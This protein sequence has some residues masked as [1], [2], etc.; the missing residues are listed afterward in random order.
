MSEEKTTEETTEETMLVEAHNEVTE[1]DFDATEGESAY[2]EIKD[3]ITAIPYSKVR[4][5]KVGTTNAVGIGLANAKAFAEDRHLFEK[6][7]HK[8]VFNPADYDNFESRAKGFWQ[9]DILMRQEL[10]N[11]G[12]LRLIIS[13]VNPLRKK[14]LKAA[15]YL[16]SEDI[17]LSDV[18]NR[19]N[20][21]NGYANKADDLGSLATLF[22]EHW[23]SAQGLC[24]IT[25]EDITRAKALGAD[26][27]EA[28]SPSR[29]Q[30]VDDFKSL[31]NR[32]AEYLREAIEEVRAAAAYIYRNNPSEMERYPSMFANR[33]KKI[34]SS[35]GLDKVTSDLDAP[36]S[37]IVATTPE[38]SEFNIPVRELTLD[39]ISQQG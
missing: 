36:T 17:E 34:A 21:G 32:A 10:N 9:A 30:A 25:L 33:R 29:K 4:Q 26:M 3:E 8:E 20:K 2:D 11:Q 22:T 12:P 39:T 35:K 37:G 6:N 38:P 19:I 13:K 27:L 7:F 1:E 16:W 24:N 31:R 5:F 28:I 23:E 18:L 14:L 15:N